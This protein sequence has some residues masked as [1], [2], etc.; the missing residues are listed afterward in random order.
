[1]KK[2][3]ERLVQEII[4]RTDIIRIV[5]S[6]V[7]LEKRGSRWTGLCPFHNEKTP[8]FGVNAEKG[9]FY[10]FGCK[11]GGDAITFIREIEKCSYGEALE[12]LAE[13]AGITITYEGEEDPAEALAAKNRE[14][15]YELHERLAGT[16]H[17]LLIADT[18]GVRALAYLDGRKVTREI[19]V[20]FRIGYAPSNRTWLYR[21]LRSKSYSAE[22][23][24]GTGLFSKKHPEFSIFSERLMFPIGDARGRVT[25]FGGRLMDGDGPKYLNSPETIIFRKHETLFGLSMAAAAMRNTGEAFIC[26]GYMDTLAFHAAGV[27]NAIAPLG[28]AFTE[29]QASLIKRYAGVAILSFDSDQAGITATER[30][31][32]IA[33]NNGLTVRV[34]KIDGAK[35]PAEILEKN[36]PE[37]LK[38]IA[39]SSITSDE[40]LMRNADFLLHSGGSEA[41]SVAFE[42]LFPFIAGFT[43]SIRRDSFINSAAIRLGADPDSVRR[44][45]AIFLKQ[46]LIKKVSP[47]DNDTTHFIPTKDAELIAALAGNPTL[48]EKA[49]S[50]IGF[51]DFDDESIRDAFIV[52]EECYRNGDQSI[53]LVVERLKNEHLGHFIM[54][55]LSEGAYAEN[56]EQYIQDGISRVKE[57]SLEKKKQR[58]IARLRDYDADRD[59]DELSLNDLL[60]EKMHLDAEISRIKEERHGR[61]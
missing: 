29:N 56:P 39:L 30:A 54:E 13:K 3:P 35:D 55:K 44:D 20:R 52:M 33:E 12:R 26:E 14:S 31:I 25:A 58:I 16:F 32:G 46:G 50:E 17:H 4:S 19:L 57:H 38:N 43:S 41:I 6:Y 47:G 9:F 11:K 60:F 5:G 59:R 22:F 24:A 18:G 45:F 53:V 42:Y 8:S 23:L 28:T 48:F 21:F 7:R 61:S 49:R 37:R 1:M 36:G 2:I 27:N 10:C 34:L 51:A 15:L 40:F